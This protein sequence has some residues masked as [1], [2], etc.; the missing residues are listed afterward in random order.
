MRTDIK[1]FFNFLF[2]CFA[3]EQEKNVLQAITYIV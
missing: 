1:D 3:C 2:D